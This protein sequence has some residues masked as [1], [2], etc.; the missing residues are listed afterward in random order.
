MCK[1]YY[2]L[3][4]YFGDRPSAERLPFPNWTDGQTDNV[5]SAFDLQVHEDDQQSDSSV[6]V[7]QDRSAKST[8]KNRRALHTTIID[9]A[10]QAHDYMVER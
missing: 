5:A 7:Q 3:E 1:Y 6:S 4:P 2:E 8:R 10:K 9:Q